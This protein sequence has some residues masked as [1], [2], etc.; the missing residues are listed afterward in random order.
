MK[1]SYLSLFKIVLHGRSSGNILV[2][3]ILSFTFSITVILCTFGLMDGFDHLLKSGLRHSTGDIVI[4]S[5]KGFF[6]ADEVFKESLG[7]H[8]KHFTPI[9]QSEAFSIFNG[10]SSGIILRGI[11]P[12]SFSE[13]TGLNLGLKAGEIM[14]G[15]ELL[16]HL[17]LKVG[18]NLAITL[19]EGKE[20]SLP[21]IK[22]FKVSGSIKHGIYQKDLRLAYVLRD[23][24]G[25]ILNIGNKINVGLISL[26]D[27]T[28]PINDL[29]VVSDN[30]Q[31]LRD[32]L[33]ASYILKP[34]WAE[35]NY[36]IEA[37]KVEKFSISLVLQLIVVV[38]VFNILAFVIYIMEKKSQEFFFLRAVGLSLKKLM[39]FWL[40]TIIGIWAISCVGAY[41][42][43]DL[44]DLGLKHLPL[45]KVPGE[46]YVLSNLELRLTNASFITVFSIA[47]IWILL[48]S[49]IG[50]LRLKNKTII[51]GLRQEFNS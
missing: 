37:V 32:E 19:G 51:Q 40:K 34:F 6:K 50:Y 13:V 46:I 27:P 12:Q 25:I 18:D 14:V 1:S 5:K 30:I 44:F 23:D 3:T 43:S 9:V 4:T 33:D 39:A 15:E 36:L 7:D 24:L 41:F 17:S 22:M 8:Q 48:A 47:F 45:F 11:E 38:A 28:E 42:L 20:N 10:K 2:A 16:K 21:I 29:S 26:F 31:D 35:Y 49:L